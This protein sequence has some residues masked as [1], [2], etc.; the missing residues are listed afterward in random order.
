MTK[1]VTL[2]WIQCPQEE[3]SGELAPPTYTHKVGFLDSRI[4]NANFVSI[5][6]LYQYSVF[7]E[8]NDRLELSFSDL[9]PHIYRCTTACTFASVLL[10]LSDHFVKLT[11]IRERLL[12][13]EDWK[14]RTQ[15]YQ[16][17]D[18]S[19]DSPTYIYKYNTKFWRAPIG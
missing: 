1:L 12:Q 13:S 17:L 14:T 6:N 16:F 9:A 18:K 5:P 15:L 4:E 7:L 11:H 10:A 19:Q 2:I 8:E 3:T